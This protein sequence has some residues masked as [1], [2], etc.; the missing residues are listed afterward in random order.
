MLIGFIIGL[1]TMYFIINLYYGC[2]AFNIAPTEFEDVRKLAW[3]EFFK[4]LLF[5]VYTTG[6]L[7]K[8]GCR[9]RWNMIISQAMKLEKE[10][11][12]AEK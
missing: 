2:I 5:A 6:V 10:K 4:D 3:K 9:L 7:Q 8:L 12:D 11:M 1:L